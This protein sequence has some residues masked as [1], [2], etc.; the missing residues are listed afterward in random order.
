MMSATESPLNGKFVPNHIGE[1]HDR[2]YK[3]DVQDRQ[4]WAAA[5]TI[6]LALSVALFA[7]TLPGVAG[8]IL[9]GKFLTFAVRSLLLLVT[10]FGLRALVNQRNMAQARRQLSSELAVIAASE[11]LKIAV[12]PGPE[13]ERRDLPRAPCDQHLTVAAQGPDG[14][15]RFYGR[16]I[17]I[18]EHG[19]GAIVPG[20]L[21]PGQDAV[22]QFTLSDE[23]EQFSG[24]TQA[25]G[26]SKFPAREFKLNAIV[27]QRSGFRYGFNFV[28]MSDADRAEIEKY[29]VGE[30]VVKVATKTVAANSG[31]EP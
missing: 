23:G 31:L 19:M 11:T 13:T 25:K 21:T 24:P 10:I 7:F 18:C 27:R 17:D 4:H 26:A 8:A 14:Q 22:L 3:L 16:I 20:V 2:L 29:R 5:V 9:I 12:D 15:Q 28:A 30:S 6:M 1:A